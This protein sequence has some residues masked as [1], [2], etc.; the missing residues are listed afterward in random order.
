MRTVFFGNGDVGLAIARQLRDAGDEVVAAVLHPA[1]RARRAAEIA[2]ALALPADRVLDGARLREPASVATLRALEPEIG[3]SAMF[4]YLL[5]RDVLE[6]FPR[7]C[8]NLHPALLPYNRGAHPNVWSIVDGTPAGVTLHYVDEGV[9]TGDVV[10]QRAVPVDAAD[11]GASLYRRLESAC[12]ALFAEAWPCVRAGAA[13]RTPQR[14]GDGTAHRVADLARL[15]EIDLDRR[16][17]GRE[18]ID[19]LRART[20]PPHRGA[21]FRDGARRVYL[22][23]ALAAEE[24]DGPCP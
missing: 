15:D 4:G 23:L 11:T 18:L 8:V 6:L 21:F 19:L 16:Y 17:T 1:D 9:D 20:F 24:A 2:D 13:P 22:H 7:G 14:A 5:R 10:A 12:E 3:V